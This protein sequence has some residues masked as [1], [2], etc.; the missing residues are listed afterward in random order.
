MQKRVELAR[1]LAARP[2]LLLLDEPAGGLNHTEIDGLGAA[3]PP[4]PRRARVTVLLVEHHMSMVMSICDTV[5]ALDFGKKIA[6][7][8]PAEV[9]NDDGRDPRL[10]GDHDEMSKLLEARELCAFYGATQVLHGLDL[11]V[12]EG[13][14]TTLLGANG[15]GKTTT[16]RALSG[17][18]RTA[19]E[20]RF[21]GKPI[22]GRATEDIVRLGIAHVPQ[23]RG[24]FS[25]QTVE[26]NLA[27][28][29]HDAARP[30][31]DRRRHR[32]RLRLFPAPEGAPR[33]S[34]PARC[35][36]ASSRCSRSAAP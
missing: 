34:R 17:M 6:E 30:H 4:H 20:I 5:V 9:Q 21:D 28:R 32:A 1:A 36:A 24:T 19:G 11:E 14:I 13:G 10:S 29:R 18:C 23:G 22:A 31:G 27:D 15:A 2:K 12:D 26:E 3:D 8:T 33:A 25:R 7:G 16:L 35:R